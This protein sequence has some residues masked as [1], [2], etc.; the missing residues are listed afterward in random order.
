MGKILIIV[1]IV[2]AAA[3]AGA[4]FVNRN[5]LLKAKED[6]AA[7][8]QEIVTVKN[9]L[10]GE[11]KKY[12]E[13]DKTI[14]ELTSQKQSLESDLAKQK[15]EVTAKTTQFTENQLKLTK[16]EGELAAANTDILTKG[17]KIT[18]LESQLAAAATAQQTPVSTEDDKARISELEILNTKL[19]EDNKNLEGK[20]ATLQRA[21]RD[22]ES[23]Q[24]LT[25]MTGRVVAVNEAWN[26]VALKFGNTSGIESNMEFLVKRGAT[27]IGKVRI[28]TVEPSISIA[29]IIPASLTRGLRIQPGDEI[30]YQTAQNESATF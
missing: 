20:L 11:I 2:L 5:H 13:A 23:K 21:A 8:Q 10:E 15:S 18:Q 27:L 22:K 24:V 9:N 19:D 14:S 1:S 28:T 12:V 6:L 17:E 30:I 29:D 7:S 16:A 4:G 26:F 3:S 25:R